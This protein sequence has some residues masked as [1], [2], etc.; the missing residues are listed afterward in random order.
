MDMIVVTGATAAEH[1][2]KATKA[3]RGSIFGIF[4]IP[5]EERP[6][7][8]RANTYTNRAK[9]CFQPLTFFKKQDH[10][11]TW[12]QTLHQRVER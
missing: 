8:N 2:F 11:P 7:T 12:H 3:I 1:S 9:F 10:V 5:D 4:P 6:L